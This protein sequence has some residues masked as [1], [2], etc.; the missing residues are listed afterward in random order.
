[1]RGA[2]AAATGVDKDLTSKGAGKTLGEE[3]LR[4]P[5]KTFPNGITSVHGRV[6]FVRIKRVHAQDE[7]RNYRPSTGQLINAALVMCVVWAFGAMEEIEGEVRGFGGDN[8]EL[9]SDSQTSIEIC[10]RVAAIG[11]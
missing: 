7:S 6:I 4:I 11:K 3:V 5:G 8:G 10:N 9:R 1:L 2:G